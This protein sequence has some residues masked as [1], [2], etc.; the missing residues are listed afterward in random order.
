M[1]TLPLG[2]SPLSLEDVREVA[3]EGRRVELAPAALKRIEKA[4]RFLAAECKKGEAIYGL[5]TG[6]GPLSD[7]RI[8]NED[9][10]RLQYNFLRSHASGMGPYLGDE[11]VR[12]MLLLRANALAVGNSGVAP[13]TIQSLL[14]FLNRGLCPLVP[15]QGS[16]GASGD[17]APLAHLSLVLIGEG[18]ARVKGREMSGAQALRAVGLK[19]LKLGPKE[20]LALTNGTQFMSAFGTLALLEAEH[21][22]D[23]A[24][25]TGA[26]TVEALRGTETA[27]EPEI[28]KLRPHP[29]QIRSAAN[30][31]GLLLAGGRKSE[32]ARSHEG[33]GKVQDPY[34]LR[35]IP[36]VHG[37][38]RDAISWVRQVLER[39]INS[40][41][42]NPLVFP[43]A[44]K[45]LSG[46]NFHGQILAIAMDVLAI[47]VAELASIS[48]RR[49][50]KLMNPAFSGL[51][52][53]L[54]RN[55]GLNSGLMI[56]QYAAAAIV[57]ENKGLCH[58]ASV[59]SIPTSVD[60]EDH[61]S[62]GA[63]GARKA[64]K[65]VENVRR[66]L[67]IELFAVTQAIDLLRPLRTSEPLERI[68][69]TVR[70]RIPRVEQDRFIHDDL[71]FLEQLI[72]NRELAPILSAA[73]K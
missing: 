43:D 53:F 51:P 10:E 39:E 14:V 23:V 37:A 47:A 33:C 65:V 34:S 63:W 5:N 21:L 59:D 38:S 73:L 4:H 11:H 67:A 70:K 17:L 54:T 55:S 62:M 45:I 44:K 18:R 68:H 19:P 40:V 58:P 9:I 12:A 13:A 22:C 64:A 29:G 60:K 66:V 15:E 2:A 16:V 8:A 20:G 41:T 7:V 46:G 25:A 56:T 42:D 31:R 49:T 61:V 35:C 6:F 69:Q 27:F 28:H 1:A 57:S 26:M 72:A 36:Q 50:D 52:I 3:L 24:D 32:I 71:R 30:V 48:E